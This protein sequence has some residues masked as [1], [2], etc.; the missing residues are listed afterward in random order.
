VLAVTHRGARAAGVAGEVPAP[1][2]AGGV[3]VE[4]PVEAFEQPRPWR[5]R[6][7]R[8]AVLA[9]LVVLASFA[10][11]ASHPHA[12]G[13]GAP[14]E[15]VDAAHLHDVVVAGPAVELHLGYGPHAALFLAAVGPAPAH[16]VADRAGRLRPARQRRAPRYPHPVWAAGYGDDLRGGRRRFAW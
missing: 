14:A 8:L 1:G 6:A 11:K 13:G 15:R 16:L 9:V 5:S 7:E 4:G 12:A 10:I 2:P 3:D